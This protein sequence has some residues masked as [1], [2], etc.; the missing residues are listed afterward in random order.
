M[1]PLFFIAACSNKKESA[2]PQPSPSV[3]RV[4]GIGKITPRGGVSEL[5]AP[6][7]GIVTRVPFAPGDTVEKGDI[8]LVVDAAEE[9]L[10]LKEADARIVAQQ[11]AA[12]SVRSQLQQEELAL[13]EKQRLLNDA[14]ELLDVGATTGEEVR[15]LE[16]EYKQGEETLRK[17]R[18][19]VAMQ[20]A[21]LKEARVQRTSRLTA[22]EKKQFQSPIDGIL[23]DIYPLVGEALNLHEVYAR[24]SATEG[25][26]VK[27]EIDELFATRLAVGQRCNIQLGDSVLSID[28][29]ILRVSPDLKRKSLFSDSGNDLEDRRVREIEVSLRNISTAPLIETKVE[30]VVFL[31]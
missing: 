20:E 3:N 31:K 12:E 5:A 21:Q 26:I 25:L 30:C 28:E 15:T 18:N 19:D 13:A 27:A 11:Y 16:S 8:L 10:S 22:L 4:V 14:R 23:L 6:A 2:Q 17:L 1:A 24:V 9:V 7:S 29:E